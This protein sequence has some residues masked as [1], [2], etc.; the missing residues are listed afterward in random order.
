MYEFVFRKDHARF[1]KNTLT[2]RCDVRFVL[3][4]FFPKSAP[5]F[6]K[7]AVLVAVYRLILALTAVLLYT[8][9]GKFGNSLSTH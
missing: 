5:K 9:A 8:T 1:G 4:L 2:S 6:C 3:L 7:R